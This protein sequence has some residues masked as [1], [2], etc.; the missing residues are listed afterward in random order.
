MSLRNI[1]TNC[2]HWMIGKTWAYGSKHVSTPASYHASLQSTLGQSQQAVYAIW[3]LATPCSLSHAFR[4]D[5][6]HDVKLSFIPKKVMKKLDY[7]KNQLD[8]LLFWRSVWD[9]SEETWQGFGP[10]MKAAHWRG[11]PGLTQAPSLSLQ[12]SS[13]LS[14]PRTPMLSF[15]IL[16]RSF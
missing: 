8:F 16:V 14:F 5:K 3:Y 2:V 10:E 1:V 9:P 7:K 4:W 6:S 11:S 12:K 15:S 13:S